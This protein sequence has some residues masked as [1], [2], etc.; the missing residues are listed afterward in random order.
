MQAA[1]DAALD[2]VLCPLLSSMSRLRVRVW[3]T[4][5]VKQCFYAMMKLIHPDKHG[6]SARSTEACK[7]LQSIFE[8]YGNFDPYYRRQFSMLDV[9][10][11][12][13]EKLAAEGAPA[14][15]SAAEEE[16]PPVVETAKVEQ[17]D[18]PPEDGDFSSGFLL[19]EKVNA[20]ALEDALSRVAIRKMQ[21][22][23][24]F[25]ILRSLRMRACKIRDGIGVIPVL[26][27][28]G[29][30]APGRGA[31]VLRHRLEEI[32]RAEARSQGRP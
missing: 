7:E 5:T 4:K 1:R 9:E 25:E 30:R 26:W 21:N 32:E 24:L 31:A 8:M 28:A 12:L 18:E 22:Y 17:M 15:A 6:N 19:W 3:P 13:V 11:G 27:R 10:K 20:K 14:G 29:K 23:A 2:V 16:E